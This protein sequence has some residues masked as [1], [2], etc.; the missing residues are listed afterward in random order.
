[1]GTYAFSKGE[2][3]DG[4]VT[5]SNFS[6]HRGHV[7]ADAVRFGGGMGN[8]ERGESGEEFQKIS[9]LPR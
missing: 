2:S 3:M 4:C 8:I 6:Q 7:T 9:G 5:L 1:M